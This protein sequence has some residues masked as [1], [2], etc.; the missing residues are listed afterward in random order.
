[1][2][3][4]DLGIVDN[5]KLQDILSK[6]PKYRE[7]QSFTWKQNFKLIMDSVEEY[8]KKWAR[9][10]DAELDSLS[11]WIKE[12][13]SHIKH[14]I[15]GLSKSVNTKTKSAFDDPSVANCLSK[16]HEQYVIV[17][18]DKASNN[19]VFVCKT[20]YIQCLLLELGL[21]EPRKCKTYK[22]ITLSKDEILTN[23]RSV[24]SS[25][26]ISPSHE[27]SHLPS[28]YWIPKL[29]KYPHKQRFIAGSSV[30]STKS[31]SKV[32][33]LILSKIKNGIQTCCDTVYSRSGINQ[34]WILKN[35][36]ELLENL[37]SHSLSKVSSIKTF[38]FST[39]YT[40]IPHEK[41]KSRLKQLVSQAFIDKNGN[42]RYQYIVVKN[43]RAYFVKEHSDVQQKYNEDDITKMINFLID[44]IFVEFGG[45]IFQQTIGIP[46][47]TNCAP[48]L[49]DLFLYSY[50][51]DF[52]RNMNKSGH[53]KQ[54]SSFNF[55]FRYI[56]DVLSLN[57]KSFSD[58]L[59]EI[60]PV[61]LEIK[62]TTDS[63]TFVNY[64]DLRLEIDENHNLIPSLF[65]KRD[66]FNF[67]IVNFPFIGSNIPA[68]PAYGVFVSQLIRYARSSQRYPD[69]VQR[70]SQL[71]SKLISQGY[72][73]QRLKSTF[74]KF[75]GRHLDL[76]KKYDKAMSH[77]ATDIFS[78]IQAL[79]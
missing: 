58:Y 6:G 54:C 26:N 62:D 29:H 11:E 66:D 79:Q 21:S 55:T 36:K 64:L 61:E 13:R 42:R 46:M 34:M 35:S 75:Y 53:K 5:N 3:T 67:P 47:G 59:S 27:D 19:I 8:A 9:K 40:T 51:S 70:S 31:L 72:L 71:V 52:I 20:Y 2:V 25:F 65:D 41:L 12:I 38:D 74:K 37:K 14:R 24:L 32:L 78:A 43:N 63:A 57:K 68:S 48:L 73:P 10:E 77:I 7:P 22:P 50:E 17:P 60:Y 18:A 39:L 30:C 45:R 49:A 4:G 1:M 56:D 23:H 44:N 76:V 28:L 15:Y 69:F 16:L 33:T